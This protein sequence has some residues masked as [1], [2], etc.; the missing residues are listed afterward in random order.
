MPS[1]IGSNKSLTDTYLKTKQ[2]QNNNDCNGSIRT[3]LLL[4]LGMQKNIKH[5]NLQFKS[6]QNVQAL[7]KAS[8]ENRYG[9][10]QGHVNTFC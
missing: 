5:L 1:S 6:G 4:M 9:N 3:M 2:Y 8:F 10:I 7:Q